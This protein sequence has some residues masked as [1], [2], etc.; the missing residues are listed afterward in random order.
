MTRIKAFSFCFLFVSGLV[1]ILGSL[2]STAAAAKTNDYFP[3]IP[4]SSWI[5]QGTVTCTTTDAQPKQVE[6]KN[7][8]WKTEVIK[9]IER[10]QVLAVQVKGCP[11][12]LN[13]AGSKAQPPVK[14]TR[15]IY[16]HNGTPD[17]QR[18]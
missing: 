10:D 12:D 16:H 6:E 11:A 2:F 13:W 5:Y 1:L 15:Y 14:F 18:K 3:L 8:I 7:I 17:R 9:T 4:G